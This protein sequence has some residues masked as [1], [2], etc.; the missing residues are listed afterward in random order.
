[1]RQGIIAAFAALTSAWTVSH[2]AGALVDQVT[3]VKDASVANVPLPTDSKGNS[4]VT[5]SVAQSGTYTITV[6]DLAQPAA[7]GSLDV[8]VATSTGSVAK[9][10]SVGSQSIPLSANTTYTVQPLASAA[11]GEPGGTLSVSATLQGAAQP[12]WQDAWVVS[13][14]GAPQPG[15]SVYSAQFS[16][17]AANDTYTLTLS[18][19]AFPTAL[20]S[21]LVE[22]FDAAGNAVAGPYNSFGSFPLAGLQ[23][24][25]TYYLYEVACTAAGC[26][27]AGSGLF[28]VQVSG[29]SVGSVYANTEPVG[30]LPAAQTIP[31]TTA[32]TVSLQLNDLAWPAALQSLQFL[33]AQGASS[34]QPSAPGTYSAAPGSL[35]LYVVATPGA[36]G[37]GAY[38]EYATENGTTLID[39]A[40]PV[41]DSSH[42]GYAFAAF[43][44]NKPVAAGSLQL[45][46]NDYAVPSAFSSLTA[47]AVQA[48]ASVPSSTVSGSGN[49]S[50]FSAQAGA[51][52]LLA[53]PGLQPGQNGLFGAVVVNAGSGQTL[54]NVTQGVGA[55]FSSQSVPISAAGHY[56]I[57]A[58]DLG[59]P[60]SFSNLLVIVTSGQSAVGQVFTSGKTSFAVNTAGTYVIN[61]LSQ[62]GNGVHY[63]EYGIQLQQAPPPTAS[64]SASPTS[65]SAGGTTK[66]TWSSTNASSC[67]ASGGGWSG[68]LG[69]SGS[70]QS[71]AISTATLFTITCT[72]DGGP[73]SASVQVTLISKGSSGGGSLDGQT[74]LALSLLALRTLR[75]RWLT[76]RASSLMSSR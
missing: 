12:V 26:A 56:T 51:L 35:Q 20:Q 13:A 42:F 4:A 47:R 28:G 39:T 41:V 53:F 2:A 30:N 24:G 60:A 46:I 73:A 68:N 59:F 55:L 48:G 19:F 7:L 63:G 21:I 14:A 18:D 49:S 38:A 72:G 57:T 16:T 5:F 25:T 74:L 45:Q 36:G 44:P 71:P 8:S 27:Q 37:T 52:T 9:F 61:V 65:V 67:A 62:V 43:T 10:P 15:E 17:A 54:F 22:V 66:L 34:L 6:T 69:P 75:Q 23:T 32:G 11:A 29:A 64:L 3:L 33:V 1:V 76:R 70:Q 50:N 40:L 31:V 58:T